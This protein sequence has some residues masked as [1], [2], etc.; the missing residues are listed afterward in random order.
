M[1]IRAPFG[2]AAAAFF[3]LSACG[4]GGN[5]SSPVPMTNLPQTNLATGAAASQSFAY[6]SGAPAD[7]RVY[8]HLPLR[9]SAEL[10]Q[11]I[12]DQSTQGSPLYH[13]FLTPAQFRASYGPA[14]SDLQTVATALNA[15]GFKTTITSQGVVADAPQAIVERTFGVTLA[16]R[17]AALTR[18]AAPV[19]LLQS[20]K[21]PTIPAPLAKVDATVAA[22]APL[23][24]L[25][26]DFMFAG[27]TAAFPDNR[28][29]N[30]GPYWFD[31][32]KQAYAYPSY[33][34]ASGRGETI[35]ILAASDFL[36]SDVA[37]YFGHENLTPPT[38]IRR[39]VDGGSPPFN[40]DSGYSDEV[41]LDVQQS[42]GSA[43]GAKIIVYEAPDASIAPSF[44]DMYTAIDED[45][46]ADVVS[47]SFGLCELYF[48]AAYNDGEDFTYLFQDFHD[49][50]RQGNAQGITFMNSS[51]DF[52][53]MECTD[54]TGTIA[55]LGIN[56][57]ANDPDVTAVGGT[58][59]VTTYTSTLRSAYVAE[60]ADHDT[61]AAD[62]GE[63]A[64]EI[65][66]SG[67][68]VS[69]YWPKP[70]YQ[71]L[72]NTGSRMRTNPDVAMH[73]GGC[74]VGSVT[75]CGPDRSSDVTALG[76]QFYLLIGTSASS[77]EFA[78]LQAVQDQI[79]HSRAGNANYLLYALAALG[80]VG[81]GPVFHNDIPGNNGYPS[82][83]GYNYVVGNGTPYGAQYALDPL[84]PLAGNPQTPSNP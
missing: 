16:Q 61:F 27:T 45:N 69:I 79:T 60:N 54:P 39:P 62:S 48:T 18:G 43:P 63:P 20:N 49:L 46:L 24:A 33:A 82:K 41:S 71:D 12:A 68:G 50:Y 67:G 19:Q 35:A 75:P 11:L 74:P 76:G 38:V 70:P 23:P 4:G 57:P 34:D 65:W 3:A 72:V 17:S 52:G 56:W 10:D 66:G 81:N 83:R 36:D 32:L 40:I 59:L 29:S 44:L 31:D 78:G 9:N 30:V 58:N 47:T 64:G 80:T 25:K 8:V 37:L 73:M 21:A 13:H 6:P 26:P 2:L 84:A 42:G 1:A 28:Y 5:S 7:V 15:Q 53:A 77:P 22:F 14:L 51:G 55:T